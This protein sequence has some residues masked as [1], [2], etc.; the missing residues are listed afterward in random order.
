MA[1]DA[2][3]ERIKQS[4]RK[5]TLK[6]WLELNDATEDNLDFEL[7]EI[8]PE[9]FKEEFIQL[10]EARAKAAKDATPTAADIWSSIDPKT[11]NLDASDLAQ[12]LITYKAIVDEETGRITYADDPS[13]ADELARLSNKAKK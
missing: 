8:V 12:P 2:I 4:G 10:V 1:C 13:F 7:L 11:I 5:P 9:E 3:L 6:L